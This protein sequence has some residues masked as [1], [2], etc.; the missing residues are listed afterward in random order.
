MSN[1]RVRYYDTSDMMHGYKLDKIETIEIPEFSQININDAIEYYEIKKYFDN[2]TR[3]RDWENEV[4]QQYK[5]KSDTLYGLTMRFFNCLDNESIISN[6]NQISL[7]YHSVFWEL[8]EHCKLYNKFSSDTLKKL[9]NSEYISP[10]DIFSCKN[11]VRKYGVILK[12]YIQENTYCIQLLLDYYEQD[13]KENHSRKLYLPTELIGQDIAKYFDDYIDSDNT[14]PNHLEG[15]INIQ[16][17]KRFPIEDEIRLKAK[18][19]HK[20]AIKKMRDSGVSLKSSNS[21]E[22]VPNQEEIVLNKSNGFNLN[23]SYSEKHLLETLDYPSILNNFIHV[24]EYV[25]SIQQRCIFVSKKSYAGIFEKVFGSKSSRFYFVSYFFN[26]L[27]ANSTMQLFVY[28]EF[29]EKNGIKLENVLKW[30]FTQYLQEEFGCPEIR[31]SFP[32]EGSTYAEKCSTII[33]AFDIAIKQFFL[34]VKN[35]EIDFE[36]VQMSTTPIKFENIPSLIENKYIYGE[37]DKFNNICHLMYSDQS[38]LAYVERINKQNKDYNSFYDILRYEKV[39]LSDYPDFVIS[40][41]KFLE[42]QDLILVLSNG[43]I[44]E[45]SKAK[46]IIMHDLYVNEV[47]S[48]LHYPVFAQ[49]TLQKMIKENDLTEKCSLFSQPEI[50]YLNYMLNRSEYCN[51]FEIRNK[52]IHGNQQVNTDENEH[53]YNYFTLLKIFVL[54]VIKINDDFCLHEKEKAN[55]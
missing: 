29:L 34:F 28:Y 23:Y 3:S 50:D 33:T 48:K 25:D 53:Q 2:N 8:F 14:N 22:I 38:M 11:V 13:Y 40:N 16:K 7:E 19:K 10:Y 31:I 55:Q 30:F 6:Y 9:L 37:G 54:L 43:Q 5:E 51:G 45:K 12:E 18:R 27:N 21:I 46:T 49:E 24:F 39:Y 32:S 17:N 1:R 41:L 42:E 15:I 47:I 20:E 52:Y 26:M 44:L 4:F 36:L 35:G